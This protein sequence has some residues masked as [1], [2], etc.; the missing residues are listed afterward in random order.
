[1]IIIFTEECSCL[2]NMI[3][4]LHYPK[5]NLEEIY[6]VYEFELALTESILSGKTSEALRIYEDFFYKQSAYNVLDINNLDCIKNYI[7]SISLLI[8]HNIIKRGVS[9]YSAK[10]KYHAFAGLIE[11]SKTRS[12]I[13]DTGKIM[14]KGYIKQIVQNSIS[15]SNTYIRKAINYIHDHLGED[16]TLDEVANH[17]GLSKCYFCTQF[18]KDMKMSFTD[19]LTY[20]RI[21]KSKHLLQNTDKSILDIAIMVGFNSQSYFTTQ[22]KKHTGL[23]PMEFRSLRIGSEE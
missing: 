19:Y 20:I 5:P 15:I 12:E 16:L 11:K 10:A 7:I 18:K 2:I 13:I 8:C 14:I 21:Q 22:F 1:M 4:N 23:S 17:V 6:K 3:N 9:P